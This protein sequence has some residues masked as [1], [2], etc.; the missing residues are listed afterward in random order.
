LSFVSYKI[1]LP[2]NIS[3]IWTVKLP[4]FHHTVKDVPV[5]KGEFIPSVSD[6]VI[7]SYSFLPPIDNKL[8]LLKQNIVGKRYS[9]KEAIYKAIFL[10]LHCIY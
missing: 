1:T 6:I 2:V 9:H 4:F 7:S 5:N 3:I 8:I 10:S